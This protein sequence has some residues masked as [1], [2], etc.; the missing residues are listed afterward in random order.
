MKLTWGTCVL[1]I[2]LSLSLQAETRKV[3]I[4]FGESERHIDRVAA[5]RTRID[6]RGGRVRAVIGL[7]AVIA[8]VEARTVEEL[9]KLDGV[10]AVHAGRVESERSGDA[11]SASAIAAWN[12]LLAGP[13]PEEKHG[14]PRGAPKSDVDVAPDLP[15]DDAERKT[16]EERYRKQW[17]E[18]RRALPKELQR[19]ESVG[20]ASNGASYWDTSLYLAGDI[21]VGVFYQNGTAGGWSLNA[22]ATTA[23]TAQTFADVVFS[24]DYFIDAQPNGRIT[25]TY[26][27]EV[28]GSGNPLPAPALE[29]DYDNDIRLTYCTDWAFIVHVKNGG[30][31]PNASYF[32]PSLRM[33]RNFGWF[34]HIVRHETGHV[35]GTRDAYSPH[36]PNARYGYLMAAHSNACGTPGGYFS[37]AGECLDDMMAG[38]GPTLGYNSVIGTYTAGQLGWHASRGDGVLDVMRTHPLI[39]G[40]SVSAQVNPGFTASF[41]GMAVERPLLNELTSGDV[42]INRITGVQYR[43]NQTAWQDAAATD[44]LFD[45]H[46]EAFQFTTPALPNG[47][48]TVQIR[49]VNTTGQSTPTPYAQPLVVSGSSV[50]NSRPFGTLAV[51]PTRAKVGTPIIMSGNGS[52][53][54]QGGPLQYS[55]NWTGTW[56]AW[57]QS[58]SATSNA[59]PVG[60]HT[61]QMRVKDSS[62]A[63][64]LLT[65]T[66]IVEPFDTPPIVALRVTPEYRH[67]LPSA[68]YSVIWNVNGSRDAETP[69]ALLTTKWDLDCDGWDGASNAKAGSIQIV[70]ANH[71]KSDRRCI[72]IAVVDTGGN[73]TEATRFVWRVPYDHKPTINSVTFAPAGPGVVTMTINGSDPDPA[74]WDGILEYR[75]DYE[76]DGIWDTEFNPSASINIPAQYATTV[77]VEAIDRFHART[78]WTACGPPLAC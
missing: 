34:E 4:L 24:L 17:E 15:R 29:R 2:L 76:G 30:V 40:P 42:S 55:W 47:T 73:E 12:R 27:N 66:V 52:T 44:G 20:C 48:Y 46:A 63:F 78:T 69:Y 77:V 10:R 25:F 75:L 54:L 51:S 71:P 43:I 74:T 72:R 58:A 57:S 62:N 6:E 11:Q 59:L 50:T 28:D 14:P 65:R 21:A 37:G 60:T 39:D 45:S 9:A 16:I 53:D 33:D 1:T 7:S 22:T 18:R 3:L 38:W 5:L 26:L 32:G 8:D 61:V 35:F 19:G 64:H 70:N 41:T 49:A 36:A 23:S 67:W 68:S 56:S 31:W 13:R